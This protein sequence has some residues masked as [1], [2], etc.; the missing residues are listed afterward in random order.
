MNSVGSHR[1]G[2]VPN[3]FLLC[4]FLAP[5]LLSSLYEKKM[6]VQMIIFTVIFKYQFIVFRSCIYRIQIYLSNLDLALA[7]AAREEKHNQAKNVNK[8]K[9]KTKNSPCA[10]VHTHTN[11]RAQKI[12]KAIR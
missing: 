2:A 8:K 10:H 11:T 5:L 9:C 7:F 6:P 12:K 3:S 1:F 4:L